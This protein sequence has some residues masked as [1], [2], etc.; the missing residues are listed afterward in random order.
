MRNSDCS[1]NN[2]FLVTG[3]GGM[4][5]ASAS[6]YVAPGV[7]RYIAASSPS[8]PSCRG[9]AE[10]AATSS[11]SPHC[12]SRATAAI[13]RGSTIVIAAVRRGLRRCLSCMVVAFVVVFTEPLPIV[14][15][16]FRS[17]FVPSSPHDCRRFCAE[18]GR[19]LRATTTVASS[20]GS[21]IQRL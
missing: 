21:C 19:V 5:G 15:L 1:R 10:L 6:V 7:R 17:R 11:P 18:I 13:A 16:C 9:R 8:L 3:K 14:W 20:W 2:E 4:Y 12:R